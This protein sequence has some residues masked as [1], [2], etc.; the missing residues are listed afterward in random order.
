MGYPKSFVFSSFGLYEVIFYDK[1]F[2]LD[3]NFSVKLLKLNLII[4]I[5]LRH[6]AFKVVINHFKIIRSE[7]FD[8]ISDQVLL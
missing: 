2:S 4:F 8:T 1:I 6:D 3:N 7:Y 5:R